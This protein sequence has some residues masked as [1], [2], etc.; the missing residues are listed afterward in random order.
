MLN[1]EPVRELTY[2]S[3][4][5]TLEVFLSHLI[6]PPQQSIRMPDQK[7]RGFDA[8]CT[9]GGVIV[10]KFF[11][12]IVE[13]SDETGIALEVPLDHLGAL[14]MDLEQCIDISLG[15][16]FRHRIALPD[17]P[18]NG[19]QTG[20]LHVFLELVPQRLEVIGGTHTFSRDPRHCR[21]QK[22]TARPRTS[23]RGAPLSVHA[24]SC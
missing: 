3:V 5:G 23:T 21:D 22:N 10:Y 19:S 15:I 24:R 4:Q 17:E 12:G 18:R 7:L 11:A 13:T 8:G 2:H 14:T 9:S 20:P 6:P 16:D 1:A